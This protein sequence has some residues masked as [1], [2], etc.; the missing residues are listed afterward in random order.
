MYNVF[1]RMDNFGVKPRVFLYNRV[2][3]ALVRTGHLDLAMSVYDDFKR[4]GLVE[5]SVTFMILIKGMCKVGRVE[6]M[7]VLLE[8]MRV[9]LCKPDV[10]AYMAMIKVLVKE[11]IWMVVLRFGGK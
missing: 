6:E 9:S 1:K 4:S 5:E 7:L 10:F 8:R 3:D 2:M 11:G